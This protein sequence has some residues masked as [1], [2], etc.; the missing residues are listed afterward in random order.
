MAG[1][2]QRWTPDQIKLY[3]D[4]QLG[5][6]QAEVDRRIA[7]QRRE[8]IAAQELFDRVFT[9]RDRAVEQAERERSTAAQVLREKLEDQIASVR[10]EM[11][12]VNEGSERAISKAEVAAHERFENHNGV[13]LKMSEQQTA[14]ERVLA[15]L[16][17]RLLPREVFETWK[18]GVEKRLNLG[19]G[20]RRGDQVARHAAGVTLDRVITVISVLVAIG[21]LI[22]FVAVGH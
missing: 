12:L 22:A 2:G 15:T 5:S 16:T 18:D 10:R 21:T 8:L 3:V 1:N 9:E 14:A 4:A 7:T 6:L 11:D 19:T 20:E 17:E 13:L